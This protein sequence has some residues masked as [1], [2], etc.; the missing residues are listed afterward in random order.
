MSRWRL[1]AGCLDIM[2][3]SNVFSAQKVSFLAMDHHQQYVNCTLG[4]RTYEL[5]TAF[6]ER[7]V[8]MRGLEPSG[9]RQSMGTRMTFVE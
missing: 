4:R 9:L 5:K 2:I 7:K 8:A 6:K 1:S 3:K